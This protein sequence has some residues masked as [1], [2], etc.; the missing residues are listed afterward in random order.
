MKKLLGVFLVLFCSFGFADALD[1]RMDE[2]KKMGKGLILNI[3]YN[4]EYPLTVLVWINNSA[5]GSLNLGE[6]EDMIHALAN[7]VKSSYKET[8]VS[9]ESDYV[10]VYFRNQHGRELANYSTW[11]QSYKIKE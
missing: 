10:G 6:K 7:Y 11:S 2:L 4:K 5:W 3:E 1:V 9:K 8:G